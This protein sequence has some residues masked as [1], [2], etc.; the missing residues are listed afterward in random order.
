M[1]CYPDVFQVT[2]CKL[3]LSEHLLNKTGV[4]T[5]GLAHVNDSTGGSCLRKDNV[6]SRYVHVRLHA[7][8]VLKDF[9]N[10][11]ES[12]VTEMAL[13]CLSGNRT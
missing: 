9:I 12:H 5:E 7:K 4:T 11:G 3:T 2:L 1:N 13:L 6:H 8:G 10:K